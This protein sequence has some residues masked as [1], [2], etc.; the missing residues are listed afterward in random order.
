M[1][2][3]LRGRYGLYHLYFRPVTP[4]AAIFVFTL[5]CGSG[6]SVARD[7][8][9]DEET[10]EAHPGDQG[11]AGR[12]G[13][14]GAVRDAG[15]QDAQEEGREAEEEGE[16]EQDAQLVRVGRRRKRGSAAG[17]RGHLG[18]AGRVLIPNVWS[19]KLGGWLGR[20]LGLCWGFAGVPWAGVAL[21]CTGSLW[22]VGFCS[23]G[24][25]ARRHGAG[26]GQFGLSQRQP[27]SASIIS[28]FS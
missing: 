14:E 25:Y 5:R 9:A 4:G 15:G 3:R 22:A 17:L 27:A 2:R 16:E 19:W 23:S 28:M 8:R 20:M 26:R 11:Q 12:Q 10:T 1:R 21:R 18:Y 13:R 6:I 24:L 7:R